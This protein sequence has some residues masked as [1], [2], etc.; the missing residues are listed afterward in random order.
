MV[1]NYI[2]S[3]TCD[4][5]GK[6]GRKCLEVG[7]KDFETVA[8]CNDCLVAHATVLN[9]IKRRVTTKADLK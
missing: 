7:T 4:S 6:R 3:T 8:I 2:V 5:C 9:T 1:L